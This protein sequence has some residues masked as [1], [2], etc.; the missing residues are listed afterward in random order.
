MTQEGTR[1]CEAQ[2]TW[3][4]TDRDSRRAEKI[5]EFSVSP[6]LCGCVLRVSQPGGASARGF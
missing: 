3:P 4:Q 5:L 6:R 1:R 2:R